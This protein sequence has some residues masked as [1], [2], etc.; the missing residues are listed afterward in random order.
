[1]PSDVNIRVT[2][3]SLGLFIGMNERTDPYKCLRCQPFVRLLCVHRLAAAS[4]ATD[5]F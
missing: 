2:R 5:V 1:M 3:P 4:N